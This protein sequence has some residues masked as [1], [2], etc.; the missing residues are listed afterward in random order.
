MASEDIAV[1]RLV[2]SRGGISVIAVLILFIRI[3]KECTIIFR[4]FIRKRHE[5][6]KGP[7]PGTA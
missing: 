3:V 2:T 7:D 5:G 4:I 1:L 6:L